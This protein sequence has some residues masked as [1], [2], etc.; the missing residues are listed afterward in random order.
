VKLTPPPSAVIVTVTGP[1]VRPSA[2]AGY[3]AVKV[4]TPASDPLTTSVVGLDKVSSGSPGAAPASTGTHVP[5]GSR[6]QALGGTRTYSTVLI[7]VVTLSSLAT[8]SVRPVADTTTA[9]STPTRVSNDDPARSGSSAAARRSPATGVGVW[10]A[11]D[12]PAPARRSIWL[13]AERWARPRLTWV[14]TARRI[15]PPHMTTM[16]LTTGVAAAAPP[17]ADRTRS[18]QRS[19]P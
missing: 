2:A 16:H 1:S 10:A 18:A 4:V 17:A 19:T 12:G 13:A 5:P 14:P 6:A 15:G 9:P 3:V 11:A 8:P 7:H